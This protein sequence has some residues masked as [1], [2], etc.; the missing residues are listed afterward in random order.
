MFRRSL[1]S[2]PRF[3]RREFSAIPAGNIEDRDVFLTVYASV[4][5]IWTFLPASLRLRIGLL[6]SRAEIAECSPVFR[7]GIV[8]W[9]STL[10]WQR[11]DPPRKG[12]AYG[13]FPRQV[14]VFEFESRPTNVDERIVKNS[15]TRRP[16]HSSS[17]KIIIAHMT[18]LKDYFLATILP[19]VR[20]T[21]APNSFMECVV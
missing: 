10:I 6:Y 2:L 21:A 3:R 11:K 19:T 5:S 15:E 17:L 13:A 8:R 18:L 20:S 14:Y 1:T 7:V 9:S 16:L 12:I 4:N